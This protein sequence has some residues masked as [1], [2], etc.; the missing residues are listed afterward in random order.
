MIKKI[1]IICSINKLFWLSDPF[2]ILKLRN[3]FRIMGNLIKIPIFNNQ[4]RFFLFLNI[5]ELILGLETALLKPKFIKKKNN[6]LYF[7]FKKIKK[8]VIFFEKTSEIEKEKKRYHFVKKWREIREIILEICI[9]NSRKSSF[10]IIPR[11]KI[12]DSNKIITK[13][14]KKSES[15]INLQN[16]MNKFNENDFLKYSIFKNLWQRGFSLSCGL[17]FG[18]SFLAYAGNIVDVHSYLSIFVISTQN[19]RIAPK[20]L[21]AF[22][23]VGTITK[24]F[25]ILVYLNNKCLAKFFSLRWHNSL[26]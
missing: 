22:G 26:P 1:S 23:R 6:F 11:K 14:R 2:D 17:K 15:F 7:L 25:N 3:Q 10:V 19:T 12:F 9:T 8:D 21:I 18:C 13:A 20:L 16:L 24:K 5:E 4:N